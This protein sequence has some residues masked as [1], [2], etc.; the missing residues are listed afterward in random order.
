[1]QQRQYGRLGYEVSLLGMGCMRLPRIQE[2]SSVEIDKEK[3]IELIRYAAGHGVNYFDTAYAYHGTKSESLLGEALDG[4]YRRRVKIVTKQPYNVMNNDKGKI[5][6]NLENTL[7]K[8]RTNFIDVYLIHNIGPA[9]WEAIKKLN[10]IEEYE[11]FR[12]EGLIGGIAFSYHGDAETYRQIVDFYNWDMVQ[13]QQNIL[14]INNQATEA[15]IAYAARTGAAVVIMEPLRGGGLAQAPKDVQALYD[16]FPIKRT[17]AEWA[18]R[19][20]YDNPDVTCILSGMTT[21]EQLKQNIETFSAPDAVANAMTQEEK[22]LIKKVREIYEARI[23]IPCTKCEYCMPCPNGVNIPT[24]F[25]LY[26]EAKMLEVWD[27]PRRMYMLARRGKMDAAQCVQCG[28]CE[29][30]CPQNI[31]I[32][33]QLALAH[34]ALDGWNE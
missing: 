29:S 27:N 15:G 20:L 3:A 2:E 8:L 25:S 19:H 9:T 17:P 14:D 21:L 30:E 4:G 16:Q 32:M 7:K 22:D 13:I 26:N 1:M 34:K 33:D 6:E 23:S 31:K 12:A 24:V 18:F 11:K 5:R 10:V 28:L